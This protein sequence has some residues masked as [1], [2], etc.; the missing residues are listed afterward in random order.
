M[1]DEQVREVDAPGQNLLSLEQW[2]D[3]AIEYEQKNFPE[4]KRELLS[5]VL[6]PGTDT[7]DAQVLGKTRSFHPIPVKFARK[8]NQELHS[9]TVD[10]ASAVQGDAK[11]NIDETALDRLK[12]AAKVI[13]E[14]Y[15][16]KDVIDGIDAEEV[17]TAD[18]QTIAL[19]QL[20]VQGTNDFLL[21]PLR[22]LTKVMQLDELLAVKLGN[23]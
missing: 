20:R 3:L 21:K 22:M 10:M 12:V 11:L 17:T 5:K 23:G 16:W 9:L 13:A 8:V 1:A 6:F 2:I 7:R 18:L 14:H 15:G 19:C 4:D